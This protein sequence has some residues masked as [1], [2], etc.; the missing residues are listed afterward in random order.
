MQTNDEILGIKIQKYRLDKEAK[1]NEKGFYDYKDEA[2]FTDYSNAISLYKKTFP[3]KQK[4]IEETPDPAVSEMLLKMQDMGIET[5]F[6]RFDKQK[7]Q[8]TFGM[9]GICCKICFMGPCKITSKATRGVCGADADVIVARNLLRHVAGGAAAHGA[10]GRENML[11]LKNAAT[12]KLNIPIE[13]EEKV[14]AVAKAFGLDE[15]K[16]INE[17]ASQIADILLE[18]LSR[19]LPQEHKA[20]KTFAPKE[21]QEVWKKLDILPIGVYHEVTESLHRTSTGTDGDWRN[22]MKQ[23]FRT[24]LAYAWSSTLGTSIAMDCLFGLP[25]LND[26][27]INLGAIKKGYVNIALHGHSPLLVSVVVKLG[28]SE[29]FQNLAKEKGALGIQFYGVCCN[30]LSAMYRYDGVIPLSNAVGAELVVGTGALD[31]WL[32]DV[33]DVYPTVMEVARCFKTTVI[34]TSDSARLP[35]AEHIGFDHHHSN[36][37]EIHEIAEKILYRALESHEARKGIPVHIP[38]YEVEAK[39]GFSLENVNKIFGSTQVIADAIKEGKILG[40][41]NLVGC[42]NPRVVYEKAVVNVART[43]LKNNVLIMTNGCASFP[44]LKT[45][46]CNANALEYCGDSLRE[47]LAPYKIPPIWHMGECL[48]NARAS[49][50]FNALS[51]NL[52]TD[53]KDLP[54]AFSSPEW[55]NEKGIDAALGFRLLGI[56]SYHCV[57]A[58][59]QGSKNVEEFMANGTLPI[60]GSKMVVNLDP[61]ALAENIVTDM[62]TKREKLSWRA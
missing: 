35:G 38:Q 34:T 54:Y 12:G 42:S 1:P 29:K 31:L 9:A 16:S 30:G 60:L 2:E 47:F 41:V 37:S 44:L 55:S 18:D 51:Q 58:P 4:V 15:S 57:F 8:C 40:L 39:M 27:K 19:T 17:L 22:V 56:S 14:R 62:K 28:K 3:N 13:G 32:A 48:D 50:M 26:S 36:M 33:Q 53:I 5:V 43:L 49:A 24:G 61:V 10:R 6:D 52:S 20:I 45:G 7:P 11:A 46:L 21:R 59:V 23:F 25:K